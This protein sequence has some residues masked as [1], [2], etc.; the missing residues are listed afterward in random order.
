MTE[1]CPSLEVLDMSECKEIDD[2]CVEIITKNLPRL[3]TLKFNNCDKITEK[4]ME[5]ITNNCED[6]RVSLCQHFESKLR[7]DLYFC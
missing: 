7:F 2:E 3:K 4:S 6:L 5:I 1:N